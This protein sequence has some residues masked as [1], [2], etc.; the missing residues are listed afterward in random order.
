LEVS[1]KLLELH[2]EQD[3]ERFDKIDAKLDALIENSNK[4]KGFVAGVSMAFSLL[5]TTI[6]GLIVY[7]WQKSFGG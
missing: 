4:Q 6:I 2:M 7:I 3:K 5:A 1:D